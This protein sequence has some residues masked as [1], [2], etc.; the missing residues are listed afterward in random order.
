M[1]KHTFLKKCCTIIK[2]SNANTGLNAVAELNY[3]ASVSRSLLYFDEKELLDKI[4]DKTFA[5]T[6]KLKHILKLTNC[7]SVN[8]IPFNKELLTE[9]ACIKKERATSFTVIL[10]E[11]NEEWDNGRGF[12]HH[13]DKWFETTNGYSTDGCNWFCSKTKNEWDNGDGIYSSEFLQKEIVKRNNNEKNIIVAIQ[14]FDYGNEN[15]EF[16]I[17]DY[18]NE[19]LSGNK[20]N[21]GL[22]V[23]FSPDFETIESD[24]IKYV[25]FFTNHTNTFFEPYLETIYDESIKDDR[26]T[27]YLNKKNRL[28]LYTNINGEPRNLDSL[29]TCTINDKEYEVKQATK[30]VYYAE[31]TLLSSEIKGNTILYDTWSNLALN[32]VKMDDVEMEFVALPSN[33]YF[34]IG[35]NLTMKDKVI[36]SFSGINYKEKLSIGEVRELVI[37]FRV[38]YTTDK[39]ELIEGA[40]WKLYTKDNTNEICVFEYHPIEKGYLHNF[41]V[42]DSN[43]LV[44]GKYYIDLKITNGKN[45]NYF[46]EC[47][48]FEIT[49]N[50]TEIYK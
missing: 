13:K 6:S 21:Y 25:G 30:G 37:D 19:I 34:N 44:P 48:E 5:D 14:H 46:R 29:P 1:I 33:G 7:G 26:A 47:F 9:S 31:I 17:T 22:G 36:P 38:Q 24:V 8:N 39:R 11:I 27:F 2:D 18:V 50:I 45:V 35:N 23:A 41:V 20:I 3:G 42:I 28:Y 4:E 15:F 10:F 12:N 40:E 49:N 16:D 43:S 32:G